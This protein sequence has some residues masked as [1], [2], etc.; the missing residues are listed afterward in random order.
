MRKLY[1]KKKLGLKNELHQKKSKTEYKISFLFF[2][3]ASLLVNDELKHKYN[4]H[5]HSMIT[6]Y[7]KLG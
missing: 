5:V 1:Q 4:L 2:I 6:V 7:M 3:L